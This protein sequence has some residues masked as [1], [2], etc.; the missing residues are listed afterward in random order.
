VVWAGGEG[1]SGLD[2]NTWQDS[3]GGLFAAV[4]RTS[5]VTQLAVGFPSAPEVHA[6]Q[7]YRVQ[8]PFPARAYDLTSTRV[9][10]AGWAG[11]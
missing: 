1:I 8:H 6:V 5:A 9:V 4:K 10:R 11:P 7:V 2:D 3:R